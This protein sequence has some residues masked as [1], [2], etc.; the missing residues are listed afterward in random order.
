MNRLLL[1]L[2]MIAVVA[3]RPG[4]AVGSQGTSSPL[5]SATERFRLD[6]VVQG[7]QQPVAIAFLPDGRALVADRGAATLSLLDTGNGNLSLVSGLPEVVL[8][9]DAGLLDIVLHPAY[10]DN[11][12]LYLAYSTGTTERS[13]TA[14]D[15]AKLRGT[16]LV[17]RQQL[18]VAEAYSEDRFHYGGRLVL[19]DGFLYVTIGDR[20]HQDRA[21]LLSTHAGKILRLRDDGR[22]PTDNPFVGRDSALPEIWTFGHRNP[23]GLVFRP[24]TDELWSHEHGPRAGDELNLVRS[25]A[26]YGWPVISYGWQ[27][28]GGP[29]GQG[30]VRQEGMEQPQWVWTPAIAPSGMTFYSGAAF[31]TWQ[32]SLLI[33]AMAQQHLNRLVLDGNRVVLEERLL[34]RRAGRIRCVVEDSGGVIYLCSDDGMILRLRPE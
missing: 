6:T 16:S 27:Y 10:R 31:P 15:R 11:G 20:E 22:I 29:I 33:G 19:K 14:V 2:S 30:I 34:Y 4:Q 25:K 28:T 18:L 23:Q 1:L 7:L 13:T 9:E 26:N 17:E 24:R 12:W 5:Q 21:Q 3:F 8:G 32:G